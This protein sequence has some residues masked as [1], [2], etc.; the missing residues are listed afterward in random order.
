MDF[1][2]K[3]MLAMLLAVLT[4]CFGAAAMAESVEVTDIEG[5]FDGVWVQFEDAGFQ[6][7]VP[8]EWI[9][10]D[11]P[12]DAAESGFFFIAQSEDGTKQMSIMYSDLDGAAYTHEDMKAELEASYPG[13]TDV[14]INDIQAVACYDSENDIYALAALD[15][16]GT[17]M[18]VFYFQPASDDEMTQIADVIVA[19]LS[20]IE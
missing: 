3:K 5:S 14:T 1:S 16:E 17:G 11:V 7:Y 19:S 18:F 20:T 15:S 4:L 13:A 9:D 10:V 2:M 6:I 12:D 8:S